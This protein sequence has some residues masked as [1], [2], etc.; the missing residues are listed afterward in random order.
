MKRGLFTICVF[1]RLCLQLAAIAHPS[2]FHAQTGKRIAVI[3]IAEI[4]AFHTL[5]PR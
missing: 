5:A 2:F 3:S 1:F 4:S